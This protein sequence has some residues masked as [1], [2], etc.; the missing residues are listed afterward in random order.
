MGR[1]RATPISEAEVNS[2]LRYELSDRIPPGVTEPWV[3]IL[4]NGRLSGRATVDLARVGQSRKSGGMLDPFNFLTGS[5]PLAVNGVLRPKMVW[6][7]RAGVGVNLRSPG[8]AVDA[9]GN[10]ELLLEIAV[11]TQRGFDRQAV[12]AALRHPR[13]S[14]REGTGHRR[15]VAHGVPGSTGSGSKGSG[16][17][18]DFLQTPLQYLKGVGP[19]RAAD[20]QRVGLSTVE[21]LLYR[22][23]L[24]YEDRGHLQPIASL[25]AGQQVA[26][27]GRIQ[28]SRLRTTR[29]PGFK[30]LKRSSATR[31]F[32]SRRLDEPV[33]PAGHPPPR[34]H[35]VLFGVVEARPRLQMA[36]P[37]YE[38]IDA[39]E[40]DADDADE[41]LTI[42]TGRI[43]PVYEKAGAMTPKMQRRLVFDVLARMPPDLPDPFPEDVR[44]RLQL[45]DRRTAFI[46]THFPPSEAP[47]IS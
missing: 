31:R 42:H 20:L 11:G 21:D 1:R 15:S 37:D 41:A 3:S 23:P 17:S 24:R 34:L 45:P 26:I 25:K 36:N 9:S 35:V 28:S 40:G 6:A 18:T 39:T 7:L 12:R 27:A 33:V 46:E 43:V 14:T 47:E 44:R 29:R 19:K 8:A 22:F 32:N 5:L 10:R 30:I 38:V 13:N 4:D 2:Y 16:V